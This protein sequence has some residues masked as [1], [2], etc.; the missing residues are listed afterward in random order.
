MIDSN[1]AIE[2]SRRNGDFKLNRRDVSYYRIYTMGDSR[3]MQVRISNHGTWLETWPSKD[4]DPS[5]AINTCVVFSEN[6]EDKSDVS[7]DM[8]VKRKPFEATQYVYNCQ[9]LDDNDIALINQAVQNIWKNKG[10]K[11]PLANTHKH[12]KVMIL[13][14]NEAPEIITETN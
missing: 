14:P 13:S 10:F 7:V 12:A 1:R 8:E 9:I 3:H 6:G 2:L 11:D 4:Y 5:C